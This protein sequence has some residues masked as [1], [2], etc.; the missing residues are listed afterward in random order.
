MKPGTMKLTP[1][2]M[3]R[4]GADGPNL[5]FIGDLE[6]QVTYMVNVR[7]TLGR[8]GEELAAQYFV[9]QYG[10]SAMDSG[11]QAAIDSA[12]QN[13]R[14]GMRDSPEIAK[15][16]VALLEAY[17]APATLEAAEG[18]KEIAGYQCVKYTLTQP[19]D[20]VKGVV[21]VTTDITTDIK[22]G[23][24]LAHSFELQRGGLPLLAQLDELEGFPLRINLEYYLPGR[25]SVRRM[26]FWIEKVTEAE[27]QV[28]EFQLPEGASVKDGISGRRRF[29]EIPTERGPGRGQR[30]PEMRPPDRG[31]PP[32]RGGG[33]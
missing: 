3:L 4:E 22:F 15:R 31:A 7:Q 17:N 2:Q 19:E 23:A 12:I 14:M 24:H 1:T 25:R 6:G 9:E 16:Q 33:R 32:D 26:N 30:P 29:E 18:S 5:Y 11:R 10:W 27:F 28:S 20:R 21:W 8:G 13:E